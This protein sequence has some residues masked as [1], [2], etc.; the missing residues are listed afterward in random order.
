M[1]GTRLL[2]RIAGIALLIT[3]AGYITW[4]LTRSQPLEVE[5]A[6][7]SRGA[8]EATVVNTRAGTIKACRRA[9]LSPQAG[10][11]II[12]MEIREGDRIKKDQVLLELWN[13]DLQAQHDLAK[14]QLA[15]AESR[16]QESCILADNAQREYIRTQQLVEKG[17]VSVQRADDASAT[18]KANRAACAAT[19]AEVRR[20]RAQIAVSQANLDRTQL[21]APF[22]GVI[23]QITGELGEYVT[24][25]PPGIPTPPA[26]DLIDDSCLYVSAPMDEVD[27][28]KIRVGQVARITLDALPGQ[29]FEGKVR[30]IAPYVTEVEKQARTVDVEAE[31]ANPDQ[32]VL[33]VGYSA[34]IEA[35][36]D[37][38]ENVLRV[39]TQVIRQG[40]KVWV[41][42]QD[43]RLEEQTLKTGLANWAYTEVLE[44]LSEGDQVLLS[45]DN[46]EIKTGTQVTPKPPQP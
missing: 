39:P 33:L 6:T 38:R 22:A 45:G 41:L 40:N 14:Q 11:Q 43:S 10:G 5:L 27:A 44:G 32:A 21:I 34:D 7:V 19:G 30:R 25:S 29:I 16:R 8:V 23:A 37:H 28:P 24:P 13:T 4:H 26:V 9:K 15:T 42:D 3:A 12:R 1:P 31:F 2:L 18:A 35:I 46:G 36:I 20:A 17:F